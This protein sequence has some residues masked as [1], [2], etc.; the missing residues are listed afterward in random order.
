MIAED[1]VEAILERDLITKKLFQGAFARDELPR[2]PPYPSCFIINSDPRHRP[3]RHW[4]AV[5]YS[6]RGYASFFDSYGH[7]PDY[8]NLENY[9][10]QTSTGFGF[11]SKR[12]QG[13]MP[14]CGVYCVL[15]LLYKARNKES[16]FFNQFTT[17]YI[18]N[19]KLINNL[20]N[21]FI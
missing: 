20:I 8:F 16:V 11:N 19:D 3:G 1:V 17:K 12:I 21:E 13:D 5:Y 18:Q 15:Y 9:L 10:F 7:S 14:F 2:K 6:A 4:L